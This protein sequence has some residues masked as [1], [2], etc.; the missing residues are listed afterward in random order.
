MVE[1]TFLY[2]INAT[3]YDNVLL[4]KEKK[5]VNL[6]KSYIIMMQFN[7]RKEIFKCN[8]NRERKRKL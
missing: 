6:M 4:S 3:V 5:K 8:I 2:S 1:T 7:Y